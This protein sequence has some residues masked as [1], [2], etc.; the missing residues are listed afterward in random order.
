M[1]YV[2]QY[3]LIPSVKLATVDG[4]RISIINP[5]MINTDSGPDFFNADIT[6]GDQQWVGNIEIHVRASDWFRHHHDKDE[7]YDSVILHVVGIDDRPV[8]R[9]NGERIPQMELKCDPNLHIHFNN[10]VGL[11]PSSLPCLHQ[12]KS[13]PSIYLTDWID[14]LGMQRLQSKADNIHRLA[15]SLNGDWTAASYVYFARALGFGKN[16]DPFERL[17]RATNIK[18]LQRHADNVTAVEAMLFGQA[19]FLQDNMPDNDY[20]THLKEDYHFFAQKFG[21]QRPQSL[22]WKFSKMRPQNFP[23][24][25]IA[26]L[27]AVISQ[28]G[29]CS[30]ITYRL[31]NSLD[32]IRERLEVEIVGFWSNH[33]TFTSP[34]T[35]F[36]ILMG[37]TTL[38]LIIINAVAPMLYAW[39]NATNNQWS[40]DKA[41]ELL[42]DMKPEQNAL[43]RMFTDHGIKCP[44]AF[45][46]QGIIQLRRTY[47]EQRQCLNCRI[48]H[49][50]LS[51]VAVR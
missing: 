23:F 32:Q 8:F 22:Q 46:S 3:R 31:L 25:R 16:A 13:M 37:R 11:S 49:R 29:L 36:S 9:S 51:I 47:C 19:G 33:F 15:Q 41:L 50:I 10:L 44:N 30:P 2:W 17:A 27:A 34:P 48:G 4:Q 20:Y 26:Y 28:T 39:G 42:T 24:R 12:I 40:V 5:G 14:A 21:L 38:D 43:V 45:T 18:Y 7:A 35:Q 1:Q 6:I